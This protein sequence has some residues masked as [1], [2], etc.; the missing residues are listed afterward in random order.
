MD[1]EVVVAAARIA[2]VVVVALASLL[3]GSPLSRRCCRSIRASWPRAC[4]KAS[5]FDI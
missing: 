2:L 5:S 4:R 3:L 1:A